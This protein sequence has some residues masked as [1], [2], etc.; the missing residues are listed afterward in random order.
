VFEQQ[1]RFS[2]GQLYQTNDVDSG[3]FSY[4]VIGGR[5]SYIQQYSASV[6]FNGI[7][8]IMGI[9]QQVNNQVSISN[10]ATYPFA[11]NQCTIPG[12][13]T[14]TWSDGC[15]VATFAVVN[16]ETCPDR[17]SALNGGRLTLISASSVVAPAVLVVLCALL[18]LF[19]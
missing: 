14:V 15:R 4:V 19:F 9:L 7:S 1:C 18:A 2:Q 17:S 10:Y 6:G 16:D 13:Y 11:N 8:S 12:Q 5:E 3:L